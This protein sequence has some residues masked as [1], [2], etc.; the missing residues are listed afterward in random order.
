M[1]KTIGPHFVCVCKH[2]EWIEALQAL[3]L[4]GKLLA[5]ENAV[6]AIL[7]IPFIQH[8]SFVFIEPSYTDG[9]RLWIEHIRKQVSYTC[10]LILL[11][12]NIS[13]EDAKKY[14]SYGINDIMNPLSPKEKLITKLTFLEEHRDEIVKSS[15]QLRSKAYEYKMPLWKRI[16]D[17]IF[18]SIVVVLLLPVWILVP[19]AIVLESRG[20]PI[21]KSSRVGTG[22]KVFGFYKFR[23]MYKNADQRLKEFEQLNQYVNDTQLNEPEMDLVISDGKTM[24]Y[25]DFVSIDENS[26]LNE[27]RLEQQKTFVKL[28]NDPRVTKVGR[29]IRKLSID[30]LPQL[31]NVLKGEMSI[32][33]N[34]PLPL[35][36]AE[37]LTTD[38]YLERFLAPAGLTG[39]WQVEKRGKNSR[40]SPEERKQLDVKYAQNYSFWGDLLI[41]IKTIPAM[42]QREDV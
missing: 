2:T 18:A 4:N 23:S 38:S 42:I 6:Q 37:K 21:Y 32:V 14:S 39:L 1:D 24:L 7:K 41:I 20:L 25:S 17:I 30:E 36:E 26:Y 10:F 29:I 27:R 5:F 11:S 34:R 33:G 28:Q 31:F 12:D 13:K 9:D 15:R 16:F 8:V 35:Y 22:Y 3:D 19:L 40:M